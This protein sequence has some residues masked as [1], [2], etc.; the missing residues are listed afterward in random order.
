[1]AGMTLQ[2]ALDFASTHVDVDPGIEVVVLISMHDE[3]A[4]L[5]VGEAHGYSSMFRRDLPLLNWGM[6]SIADGRPVGRREPVPGFSTRGLGGP[7]DFLDGVGPSMLGVG[8]SSASG[9]SFP[10]DFSVR[11]DPG[12]PWM[13]YL[14]RGPSIQIEIEQ[15][16]A[17][18]PGGTVT[19]GVQ[20][21][22]SQDSSLLRAVG[23]SLKDPA[24]NASYTVTLIA[25]RRIQ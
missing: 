9:T 4:V 16:S 13:R 18:S 8:N 7:A 17:P 14:G 25:F 6:G 20:L 15:R 10:I 12:N 19:A 24:M 3:A 2:E 11:R 1:M 22:A 5:S 21:Q 23:P